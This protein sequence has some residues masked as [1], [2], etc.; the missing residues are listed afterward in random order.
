MNSILESLGKGDGGKSHGKTK[1]R[2]F[3]GETSALSFTQPEEGNLSTGSQE[4]PL[5]PPSFP[6]FAPLSEVDPASDH[7][8]PSQDEPIKSKKR[9]ETYGPTGDDDKPPIVSLGR[10]HIPL[11]TSKIGKRAL[12]IGA[13]AFGY[14]TEAVRGLRD[15][16]LESLLETD[17][18][19]EIT[20]IDN[21]GLN[22]VIEVPVAQLTDTPSTRVRVRKATERFITTGRYNLSPKLPP[23]ETKDFPHP[24]DQKKLKKGTKVKVVPTPSYEPRRLAPY[25]RHVGAAKRSERLLKW[26]PHWPLAKVSLSSSGLETGHNI[27]KARGHAISSAETA[28]FSLMPDL[29]LDIVMRYLPPHG[30]I[31]QASVHFAFG[32]NALR[33]AADGSLEEESTKIGETLYHPALLSLKDFTAILSYKLLEASGNNATIEPDVLLKALLLAPGADEDTRLIIEPYIARMLA[34]G[35]LNQLLTQHPGE[36]SIAL[37]N[38]IN[39]TDRDGNPHSRAEFIATELIGV[40]LGFE[41]APDTKQGG[42]STY[43][44]F[45]STLSKILARHGAFIQW[46]GNSRL[47]VEA[48]ANARKMPELYELVKKMGVAN[49]E[50]ISQTR[51]VLSAG[52]FFSLTLTP[53]ILFAKAVAVLQSEHVQAILTK[54]E[55]LREVHR[56]RAIEHIITTVTQISQRV[57]DA[58]LVEFDKKIAGYSDGQE[59][60]KKIGSDVA[61]RVKGMYSLSNSD[62]D[63]DNVVE[64]FVKDVDKTDTPPKKK[65][66]R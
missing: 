35:R 55:A 33:F 21:T 4:D 62:L 64:G 46:G 5:Y 66:R 45:V 17:T 15:R 36:F 23:G 8:V 47:V 34:I 58:A 56:L 1:I 61:A 49:P 52:E 6:T 12:E 14:T 18:D 11:Y 39:F 48:V 27:L 13:N 43:V 26:N 10:I 30:H 54:N 31:N 51:S 42:A 44:G 28:A 37:A 7:T 40:I 25:D 3:K 59:E 57:W 38:T 53:E 60:G 29:N 16:T 32:E 20:V 2:D 50:S 41:D 63:P 24:V 65:H 19:P 22:V 9:P